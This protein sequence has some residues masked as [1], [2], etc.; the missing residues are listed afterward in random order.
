[1]TKDDVV[2]AVAQLMGYTRTGTSIKTRIL[3][4]IDKMFNNNFVNDGDNYTI[5][6]TREYSD[7]MRNKNSVEIKI[8]ETHHHLKL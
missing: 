2:K 3:S 6:L 5:V 4:A 7:E 8:E 1:M